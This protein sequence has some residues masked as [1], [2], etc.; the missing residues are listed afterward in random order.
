[1]KFVYFENSTDL[2]FPTN[3]MD[4]I[5]PFVGENLDFLKKIPKIKFNHIYQNEDVFC[6]QYA[7]KGFFNFKKNISRIIDHLELH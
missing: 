4:V 5:Y 3:T 7:K 1:A 6:W 2:V